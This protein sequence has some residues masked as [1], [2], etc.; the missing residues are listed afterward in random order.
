MKLRLFK[1]SPLLAGILLAGAVLRGAAVAGAPRGM[2]GGAVASFPAEKT[3]ER[4]ADLPASPEYIAYYCHHTL[5]CRSCLTI[6]EYAR[7]AVETGFADAIAGGVLE[8]R[9]I[10]MDTEENAHLAGTFGAGTQTVVLVRREN[11]ATTEWKRLDRLWDL[12]LEKE[13]RNV[14]DY[15]RREV[16]AFLSGE[17]GAKTP[18]SENTGPE[19]GSDSRRSD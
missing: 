5:R 2:E 12:F 7:E 9:S 10:D 11:G 13:K 19:S 3:P 17:A 6:E 18:E 14:Q 15:V 1:L 16:E 8:W 4:A